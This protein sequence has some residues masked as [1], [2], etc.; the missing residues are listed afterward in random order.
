M[1]RV[2]LVCAHPE[3]AAIDEALI[4]GQP[5][6]AV[7]RRFALGDDSV[8]RHWT[9]DHVPA[10]LRERLLGADYHRLALLSDEMVDAA[11]RLVRR[12]RATAA[13]V[14]AAARV[15][16]VRARLE[17]RIGDVAAVRPRVKDRPFA[18]LDPLL[19]ELRDRG[20]LPAGEG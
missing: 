7:A 8:D 12:G 18:D 15:A 1:P 20:A 14:S 11:T 17:G 19:A 10:E 6:M 16:E 3:R 13:D 2:C 4:R 9:N 5:R